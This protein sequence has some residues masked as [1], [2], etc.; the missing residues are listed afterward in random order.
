MTKTKSQGPDYGKATPDLL[1]R[2]KKV[3]TDGDNHR[4]SV[5]AVY[6][7]YNEAYGKHDIPQTCSTCLRNRVRELR[8]YMEG[9]NTFVKVK[10]EA[11]KKDA[12]EKKGEDINPEDL[13]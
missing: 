2:I 13:T 4:Y 6:G 12:G 11:K 8:K 5:S 3:I 1:K 10:E 7:A 9:Y